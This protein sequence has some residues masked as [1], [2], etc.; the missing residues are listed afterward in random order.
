MTRQRCSWAVGDAMVAYHDNEWGRPQHDDNKLYEFLI[1]EGAQAGLSWRTILEKR[2]GYREA[3]AGFDPQTVSKYDEHRIQSILQCTHIIRNRLKVKS[4]VNNAVKFCDI[5]DKYGT[6]DRYIWDITGPPIK[7]LFRNTDEI[8]QHTY[9]SQLMSK[10]LKQDGFTFV[11]PTIC[12]A[13]MQ[14][15]GMVND[16]TVDCFLHT[17]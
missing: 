15:V 7:N 5:Q 16:H 14:A 3:F 2:E 8:P 13:F 1:L 4:A 11:G 12:Y 17:M 10:R 9:T 6:F